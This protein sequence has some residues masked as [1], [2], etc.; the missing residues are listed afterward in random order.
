MILFEGF[1]KLKFDYINECSIFSLASNFFLFLIF[2]LYTEW[3]GL[4]VY[5]RL[6]SEWLQWL[7]SRGQQSCIDTIYNLYWRQIVTDK[8]RREWLTDVILSVLEPDL[9]LD[10]GS[11]TG[12]Y[13]FWRCTDSRKWCQDFCQVILDNTSCDSKLLFQTVLFGFTNFNNY[14]AKEFFAKVCEAKTCFPVFMKELK[15]CFQSKGCL[16]K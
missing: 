2:S 14:C 3:F 15:I 10:P 8:V 4:T 16:W 12:T 5:R 9:H 7:A 13:M 6:S 1:F 11:V